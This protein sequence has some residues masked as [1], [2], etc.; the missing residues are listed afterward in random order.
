MRWTREEYIEL[1]TFGDV[2][3]QMF[4]ELF[5][6]LIGLEDEWHK[7]GATQDQIDMIGFD[8]DYVPK[9]SCGGNTFRISNLTPKIIE[10]TSE[11]IIQTD[12]LGRTT[13]LC[14]GKATIPLPLDYPVKDMDS[15]LKIKPMYEFS[16]DR[17]D[18]NA[19]EKAKKAQKQ[20]I[21]VRAEIPG[22]FDEARE[23]MGEEELC[24]G[25][26]TQPELMKD[27]LDTICSTSYQVL[28]RVSEHVTIDNLSIHEDMAGKSGS[29]I[30]P[31][32]I[33]EFIKPYY[34]KIWD[35]LSN[36]G[37]RIFSQ[38][39]DGNMEAVIDAFLDCGVTVM[40]PAEPAA[41]MDIVQLRKKYG[42]KLA[43]KGGI[44]KHVLRQSK[45]A[46]RKE[47]EY[48]M[49]PLMQQGGVVFGLDHRIPNGTP[50]ENYIYY[51]NTGREILGL[52]PLDG[53]NRGWDRMA[54]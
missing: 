16:E 48:K 18:W 23:L 27:I 44:D 37:T 33:T 53:K 11:H 36:K 51:V 39:S 6:P 14:K 10:E 38:D 22:G 31:N 19:V 17:I 52:P 42:N 35:M 30:G 46:I 13:K 2:K 5:G 9:I 40:Y 49:Q 43:F 25:Y 20:G 45:E 4:V 15:W 29:L 28:D 47:L 3:R 54:F 32:I 21:L 7:Q 12:T 41:G 1:L 24:V 8:W 26:Y 50:L 34:R